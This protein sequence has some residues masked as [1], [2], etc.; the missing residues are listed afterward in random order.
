MWMESHIYY[1]WQ[2]KYDIEILDEND[3]VLHSAE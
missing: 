2:M 3:T 1:Q